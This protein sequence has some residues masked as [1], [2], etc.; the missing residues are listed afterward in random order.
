METHSFQTSC[1]MPIKH[2]KY[3][4]TQQHFTGI[5]K[6]QKFTAII[7]MCCQQGPAIFKDTTNL[8][9]V[10]VLQHISDD[11]IN[12]IDFRINTVRSYLVF[13]AIISAFTIYLCGL[14]I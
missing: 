8:I 11:H 9:N 12:E 7:S 5:I 6:M 4:S 13:I 10:M 3:I 14:V 2:Q 1:K